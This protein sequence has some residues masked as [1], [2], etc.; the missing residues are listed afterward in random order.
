MRAPPV[1]I[2][3]MDPRSRP[4]EPFLQLSTDDLLAAMVLLLPAGFLYSHRDMLAAAV[5]G[6]AGVLAAIP[7]IL[8]PPVDGRRGYARVLAWALWL[9]DPRIFYV[10]LR[11]PGP[12]AQIYVREVLADGRR[13]R[14]RLLSDPSTRGG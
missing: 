5:T 1:P 10:H 4:I 8:F 3:R 11:S 6:V 9:F 7:L 12:V 2:P 14:R 13:G